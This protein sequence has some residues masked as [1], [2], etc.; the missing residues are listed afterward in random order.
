MKESALELIQHYKSLSLTELTYQ[1]EKLSEE[2]DTNDITGAD[3][4]GDITG[5]G[6]T[7]SCSLCKACNTDCE[8]CI[9]SLTIKDPS[10]GFRC[11]TKTY[12]DIESAKNPEELYTAIQHRITYLETLINM[13]L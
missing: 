8:K 3:V 13:C 10:E 4:L 11:V 6:S 5:F 1:W 9:H 7:G 2:W 12:Y